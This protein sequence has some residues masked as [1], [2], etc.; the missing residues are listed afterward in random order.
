MEGART[1]PGACR[2]IREHLAGLGKTAGTAGNA[3]FYLAVADRFFSVV[4]ASLGAAGLVTEKDGQWRRVVIEKPF[5]HDLPSAKALNA[6]ILK[7]LQEH[8]IYR[9]DHFLGKE[10]VQNIMALRFANRLLQPLSNRQQTDHGPIPPAGTVA[11]QHPGTVYDK[12]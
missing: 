8:Q 7:T 9:M 1:D 4:V 5:G 2:R 12:P 11:A 3:L 10:T 6:E